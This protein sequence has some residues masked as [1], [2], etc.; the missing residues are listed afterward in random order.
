MRKG[1]EGEGLREDRGTR[2]G[3]GGMGGTGNTHV[4][5]GAQR[6]DDLGVEVVRF[7]APRAGV[8]RGAEDGGVEVGGG[9]DLRGRGAGSVGAKV[10]ETEGVLR[11]R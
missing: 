1:G 2:G 4:V 8:R 7:Q 9:E 3:K 6:E 10:E 5:V 11:R